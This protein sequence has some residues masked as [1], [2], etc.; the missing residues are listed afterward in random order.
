M[1]A[2]YMKGGYVIN[3]LR[4]RRMRRGG[5]CGSGRILRAVGIMR[6]SRSLL[7]Y[8]TLSFFLVWMLGSLAET[9]A[10]LVRLRCKGADEWK[11]SM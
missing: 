1:I 4:V 8:N 10:V 2:I 11:C 9:L 5:I 6:A 3:V 7:A